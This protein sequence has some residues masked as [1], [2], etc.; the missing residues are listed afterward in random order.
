[1]SLFCHYPSA[2]SAE[3]FLQQLPQLARP[4][5][6]HSG[7][8]RTVPEL[9]LLPQ[10]Q[11]RALPAAEQDICMWQEQAAFAHPLPTSSWQ[12]QV[13]SAG[14]TWQGRWFSSSCRP[15]PAFS[16]STLC[17][18]SRQTPD[19]SAAPFQYWHRV[20][21]LADSVW[22]QVQPCPFSCP[23]TPSSCNQHW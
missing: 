14:C 10:C 1:M 21:K 20:K 7:C 3:T 16:V 12:G 4:V 11:H 5:A 2:L 23:S 22:F 6:A 19:F 9:L 18:G 15:G 17:F 13:D 8:W